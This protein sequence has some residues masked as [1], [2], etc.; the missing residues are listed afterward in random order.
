MYA[1]FDAESTCS[2]YKSYFAPVECQPK[3]GCAT[4]T[5]TIIGECDPLTNTYDLS[6]SI[7][8]LSPLTAGQMI[9]S[10]GSNQVVY[11]APFGNPTEYLIHGLVA[12]GSTHEVKVEFTEIPNCYSRT[13]YQ[14]PI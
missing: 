6:G 2:V 5:S 8:I 13:L 11:D 7:N 10:V 3:D 12:D 9:V 1:Y 4:V 14:A